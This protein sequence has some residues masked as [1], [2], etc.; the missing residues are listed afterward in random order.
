MWSTGFHK[1]GDVVKVLPKYQRKGTAETRFEIGIILSGYEIEE[2][3]DER[4]AYWVWEVIIDG[5]IR[6]IKERQIRSLDVS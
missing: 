1:E 5:Q 3:P 6:Q 2:E 4:L